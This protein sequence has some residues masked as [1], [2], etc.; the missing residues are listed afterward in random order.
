M[1]AETFRCHYPK[2]H[3]LVHSPSA[4]VL[5]FTSMQA[6]FLDEQI[7]ATYNSFYIVIHLLTSHTTL[8]SHI[9]VAHKCQVPVL[10]HR[11]P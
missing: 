2:V 11:G 7:F 1:L 4:L 5:F 8:P 9:P 10:P 3:T 6:P